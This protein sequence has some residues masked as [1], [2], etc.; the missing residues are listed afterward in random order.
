[1]EKSELQEPR[2]HKTLTKAQTLHHY[3]NV[4][5]RRF[6]EALVAQAAS[7]DLRSTPFVVLDTDLLGAFARVTVLQAKF[8]SA[9]F[10]IG[11]ADVTKLGPDVCVDEN[12]IRRLLD[13]ETKEQNSRALAWGCIPSEAIKLCI[14]WSRLT[15]AKIVRRWFPFLEVAT[16][17]TLLSQG[18]RVRELWLQNAESFLITAISSTSI[19][20]GLWELFHLD[21]NDEG[22]RQFAATLHAWGYALLN[23]T[24]HGDLPVRQELD[25]D[26]QSLLQ[27]QYV[28]NSPWFEDVQ[29]H[30]FI[31]VPL[32]RLRMDQ[33]MFTH[34]VCMS[35]QKTIDL[36]VDWTESA[37]CK[38]EFTAVQ[39]RDHQR[40]LSSSNDIEFR[41]A[42]P[43][44]VPAPLNIRK[45]EET[46]RCKP[47]PARQ[48][49]EEVI[50]KLM[51]NLNV[52]GSDAGEVLDSELDGVRSEPQCIDSFLH[53]L[54]RSQETLTASGQSGIATAS[55]RRSAKEPAG[56]DVYEHFETNSVFSSYRQPSL[57]PESDVSVDSFPE[58]NEPRAPPPTQPKI[59]QQPVTLIQ[60]VQECRLEAESRPSF[61][62][63]DTMIGAEETEESTVG[64]F[65]A[66]AYRAIVEAHTSW[67]TFV[68]DVSGGAGG[69][70][71]DS[72]KKSCRLS[73]NFEYLRSRAT[74]GAWVE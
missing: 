69:G 32:V 71:A 22:T 65:V 48:D 58:Y 72:R 62:S 59:V 16:D 33:F 23:V 45:W 37:R 52:A 14:P 26:F 21:A 12:A 30:A 5:N 56:M 28:L 54:R 49:Q 44:A 29:Q 41:L 63:D 10:M 43:S 60:N 6:L 36:L 18:F 57:S 7:D 61:G 67:S 4:D 2:F 73:V 17:Y 31:P 64:M 55:R 53:S 11:M 34:G 1:M 70:N 47:V 9:K 51:A 39:H 74:L 46:P 66:T 38:R 24:T 50:R 68:T 13:L 8:P 40:S 19:L 3:D 15:H 20:L 25:R 27:V 35:K 42:S